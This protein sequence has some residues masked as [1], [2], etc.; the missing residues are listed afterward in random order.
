[1]G[2]RSGQETL[3]GIRVVR[4]FGGTKLGVGGLTQAYK[5]AAE[6]AIAN[7]YII[8]V[9]LTTSV[10]LNY[11]YSASPEV[12]RLVKEFDLSIVSE[13]Y[14]EQ[15]KME[16]KVKLKFKEKFLE[17]LRLLKAT[18]TKLNIN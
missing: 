17:K 15:A 11:D 7:A 2:V 9:E 14:D 12:G 16:I 3:S 1:M 13:V 5:A 10:V 4:Y 6:S 8:E 18:G